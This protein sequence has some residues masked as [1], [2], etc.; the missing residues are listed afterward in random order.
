MVIKMIAGVG[1]DICDVERMKR[2]CASET[3]CRKVFTPAELSYA[4]SGESMFLH[5]AAAYA[6]K[7]AFAKAS[8]LGLGKIGLQ[9]VGVVHDENGRPR[10]YLNFQHEI[11]KNYQSAKFHVS[12]SHDGGIAAAVVICES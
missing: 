11:L 9:N 2:A 8:G 1:L 6:V 5:L 10:L 7:E 12:V 4:G 3:F